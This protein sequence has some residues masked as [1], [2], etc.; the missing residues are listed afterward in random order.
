ML[1]EDRGVKGNKH[2]D[3][4]LV[5]KSTLKLALVAL[6]VA[7]YVVVSLANNA[8]REAMATLQQE[9]DDELDDMDVGALRTK[10]TACKK[11]RT[12]LRSQVQTLDD[13]LASEKAR[14][15]AEVEKASSGGASASSSSSS[16]SSKQLNRCQTEKESLASQLEAARKTAPASSTAATLSS[17]GAGCVVS[18]A[19]AGP[20][21][22]K[23]KSQYGIVR[24][25]TY[26]SSTK[27]VQA[28]WVQM[29]CDGF[30]DRSTFADD[31]A[32]SIA[33]A[34]AAGTVL[35]VHFNMDH[36]A[37]GTATASGIVSVDAYDVSLLRRIDSF[38]YHRRTYL[39]AQWTNPSVLDMIHTRELVDG[40]R[41][42][43]RPG[44][45]AIDIGAQ[46]GD[47]TVE[48]AIHAAHTIAF[49][50][51]PNAFKMVDM[52]AKLNPGLN[53]DVHHR[54]VSDHDGKLFF[55]DGC[56]GCNSA[57]TTGIKAGTPGYSEIKVI[58]VV[59]FL[60]KH[61]EKEFLKDISF[62]KIDTEGHD[63]SILPT[64]KPLLALLDPKPIIKVEWYGSSQGENIAGLLAAIEG[65][66][67]EA[68]DP[69]VQVRIPIGY[70]GRKYGD[71]ICYPVGER[72]R[73]EKA[74]G[75]TSTGALL[76]ADDV[77]DE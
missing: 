61:Y 35:G 39:W 4:I 40:W 19:V 47:T 44:S 55:G 16:S 54:G 18:S 31:G 12:R 8:H 11:S 53:I 74:N 76:S 36:T 57:I 32:Y 41:R 59:D 67:Y 69:D 71:L 60:N 43:I 26:G 22:A 34:K 66:G 6:V 75:V 2:P 24:G 51:H 1:P 13:T 64:L 70:T 73:I 25:R 33:Y 27:A 65:I 28:Q 14:L 9:H 58:N 20:L 49:E 68:Y 50:P 45:V 3:H 37:D 38:T 21:C 77:D 7:L 42:F 46:G 48:I 56:G 29:G 23:W 15:E 63:K 72:A 30:E 10:L 17:P 52:N 5:K 62:I